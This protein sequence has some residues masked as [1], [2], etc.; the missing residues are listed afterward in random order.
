MTAATVGIQELS[1]SIGNW[2]E[3][4]L[5]PSFK[6][7]LGHTDQATDVNLLQEK[8]EWFL[9]AN[10]VVGKLASLG[11][12]WDSYGAESPNN[13]SSRNARS[14]IGQLAAIDFQPTSIDPSVE[15]GICLSFLHGNNYGDIECFN[16]GEIWAVVSG[17]VETKAWQIV[18]DPTSIRT[19]AG[20]I[21]SR[22]SS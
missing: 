6:R 1:S 12:N 21:R 17:N 15:G 20:A 3:E 8:A 11:A 18:D 2:F 10:D 13:L 19:A 5:Q 4:S 22:I 14:V 16:S 7:R 9:D